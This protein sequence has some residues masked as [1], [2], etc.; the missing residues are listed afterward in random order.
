M[1][2]LRKG[3]K[4]VLRFIFGVILVGLGLNIASGYIYPWLKGKEL[5]IFEEVIRLCNSYWMVLTLIL[6]IISV[7]WVYDWVRKRKNEFGKIWEFYGPVKKLTPED[8]KIQ[9]YKK[10]RIPRKSDMAI[11]NLLKNEEYIL[12]TGKPKMGKTR[13]SYEAIKKLEKFSVIKP[14]PAEI[15][16]EKINIPPLSNKNFVLFLD[17]LQRF[18]GKNVEDVIDRFKKKGEKLIVVATC[19]TGE[20]LDLVKEEILPLYR[21]FTAIELEQISRDDCT[22]LV[23][24]IKK[25]DREFDWKPEQFD[26][27]PGSVALDL[28]DMKNRYKKA[29]DGKVI[30][31]ALKLLNEGNL[32]LYK[33][34]HVEDVCKDIFEFPVEKLKRYNLDEIIT[35]LKE[36][37][38]ITT[39]GDIIDIYSSYLD[40]CV[41]D[42]DPSLN[43]L[44]KL[45]N[46]FVKATDSGSL[47]YLGNRFHYKKDFSH[48]KDCYLEALTI[49]PKYASAHN[50]LGYVLAKLGEAEEAKGRYDE[51]ERLYKAADKEHREA[52]GINA[53]YPIDHN[54]LGY[55]LTRLGE[56]KENKGEHDEAIRLYEE[57]EE[58]HRE[59]IRL[60]ADYA[61]AHHSLAYALEKLGRDEEAEE[62]F[63]EA[64]RLN[65]ESPFAHNLLGHL[66]A[67]LERDEEAEKE[68]R[69]AMRI[70]SDYPST[71]NNFGHL[72]AKLGKHEE[73]E[74]EYREAIKADPD[75]IVAHVNLG[76][77]L[78]NLRKFEEAKKEHRKALDI[79]PNYA[80]AHNALGYALVNLKRYDEAEKEF[81]KAIEIKLDYVEAH[82]NLGYLLV[83]LG[84]DKDEKGRHNE[85]K[86][87][88]DEA[89]KEYRKSLQTN[90]NDEDA[91]ICLGILLERLN[92]EKEAEDCYK[93][94]IGKNSNNIKARTTYGYFLSRRG[95]DKDAIREF[96]EV[97]KINS[98]DVKVR[99]QLM[100][101]NRQLQHIHAYRARALIALGR[102]DEAER[103]IS[104]AMRL[105]PNNALV[106]KTLGILRE[107]LG[108][109]AQSKEDKLRLYEEAEKGYRKALELNDMY[110]S[111]HRHLAN[112]LARLGR[113][114]EAE[115]EYRETKKVAN[116]YPKNNRDFGIFLSKI[117]RIED[118][119]KEL[120]IATELFRE[121][122]TEDDAKKT[123]ELLKSL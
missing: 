20:E 15:E 87:R 91:L 32:F 56:I 17:D 66:L 45:K 102:F 2:G 116:N 99:S 89:E 57:A 49:Y 65:P 7:T 46:M 36:N 35:N 77:L 105:N 44:M 18:I 120:E 90:P 67:K 42:Y 60:K 95:R 25:E 98:D 43:D 26:G 97:I 54:N 41:Y 122:G 104:E 38:F 100:Y 61:S 39:D 101:L 58:E 81:R 70:K 23:E 78:V 123:E 79:N 12:I 53:Y 40:I 103:G 80:E 115:K 114:G 106:H 82:T 3:I 107:E 69:E 21:G 6:V 8:F 28:D 63:R 52:I 5:R 112:L 16:I 75:Y 4:Q 113:H 50:N 59:A 9:R 76:R 96:D 118:A 86:K 55:V 88:Y 51:A 62:E 93:K 1:I 10:A 34:S 121:Q 83:I 27:S 109:R 24:D 37:D 11:E 19:R 110:P 92:R 33:K 85:A 48:A 74:K 64:I 13:S 14:R 84:K 30:L 31:R 117:G 68:Y 73:A 94:V 47:F 29:G 108:D 22:R 71:H 119:R 72:L 111:A